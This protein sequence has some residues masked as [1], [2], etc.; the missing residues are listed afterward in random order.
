[1]SAFPKYER[2]KDSGVEWLAEIP[3]GWESGR[4][5]NSLREIDDRSSTGIEELLSLRMNVGLV[6]HNDVS[7]IPISDAQLVGYKKVKP[8]EI[9]MNRMRACFGIFAIAPSHGL[10]SPD[11]A[12][13]EIIGDYEASYLLRVF[14]TEQMMTEMRRFSKGLGTGESGF[15]RLYTDKFLNI[16]LPVI[17]RTEQG[18]IV[19]F[20]DRKTAEIDAL[21]AK[22]Q[23]QI[24]LL[25]EQKPSS[26]IAPSPVASTLTP[27]SNA[28]ASNGSGTFRRGGR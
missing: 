15:L 19:T 12:V 27:N 6:P 22:K 8:G 24:E 25:D 5:K 11:Y 20:L 10:V 17:E 3:E 2:Y 26:S 16:R 23:R 13:F 4:L 9:V 28:P 7:D 14:K 21:I 1:M 18:R